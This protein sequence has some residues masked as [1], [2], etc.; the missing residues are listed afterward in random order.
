[1]GGCEKRK[2]IFDKKAM[3]HT[4]KGSTGI[5]SKPPAPDSQCS[6]SLNLGRQSI[7]SFKDIKAIGKALAVTI[8]LGKMHHLHLTQGGPVVMKGSNKQ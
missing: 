1:M 2:G 8:V 6:V 7:F 3:P 4:I 5:W